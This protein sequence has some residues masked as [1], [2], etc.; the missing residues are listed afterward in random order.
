MHM[1]EA[2]D[3]RYHELAYYTLAHHDSTYFIHQHVVDAYAAQYADQETKPIKIIFALVGLCLLLERSYTG[4]EVQLYHVMMSKDKRTW[5]LIPLP[6]TRGEVT[7]YDVV[8][9]T[10]GGERDVRIF[11]WCRSVWD[12]YRNQQDIIWTLIYSYDTP[13]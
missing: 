13:K 12:A 9:S 10:P 3:A 6:E 5:P 1:L 11:E 4:R 8:S 7:I 2:D